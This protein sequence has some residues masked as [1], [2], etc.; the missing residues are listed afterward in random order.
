LRHPL[1]RP[2][3]WLALIAAVL[4]QLPDNMIRAGVPQHVAMRISGHR[5]TK[6][7]HRYGLAPVW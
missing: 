7:F 3:S 6:M 5:T 1:H 4:A 2:P